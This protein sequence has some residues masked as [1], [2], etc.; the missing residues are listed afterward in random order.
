[1]YNIM[2]V[3]GFIEGTKFKFVKI[4]MKNLTYS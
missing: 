2:N 4:A 3:L 1:M